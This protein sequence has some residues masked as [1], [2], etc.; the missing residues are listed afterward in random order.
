M[1]G[2]NAAGKSTILR[3][4]ALGLCQESGAA[5]LMREL[6]GSLIRESADSAV[7]RIELYDEENDCD[8]SIVTK[9]LRDEST[10]EEKVR[11]ETDPP[12]AFPWNRL[13]VCGY[14]T[15]R[16]RQAHAGFETY[17]VRDAVRT[18]FDDGHRCKTPSWCCC[19]RAQPCGRKSSGRSC[20]S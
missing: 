2:D 18:L 17:T 14:G 16:G 5:A 6:P 15:N 12:Q 9:L 7:I 1:L 8:L 3:S 10:G 13:F 19:A 11:K 4:L 20:R